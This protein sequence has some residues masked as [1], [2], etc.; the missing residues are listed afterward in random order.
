MREREREYKS[1]A[2]G[3]SQWC[4]RKQR[5]RER[6]RERVDELRYRQT[7]W[8]MSMHIIY[9]RIGKLVE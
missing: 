4:D 7:V 2:T 3:E 5:E 8:W 9:V 1:Q 6:E